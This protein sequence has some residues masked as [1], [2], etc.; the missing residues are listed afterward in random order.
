MPVTKVNKSE[1]L[2][3]CWE[4]FHRNGY[5]NASLQS[6]ADASGLGKAGV[7]H[8][9]GSKEGLMHAVLEFSIEA[10]KAYVLAPAHE[11]L[12]PDQQLEKL[13]RRQNRLSKRE[14]QGCFYANVGLET[15]R[16]GVFNEKVQ[17]AYDLWIET[18]AGI[19]QPTY[20]PD[21]ARAAAYRMLL[22]YEGAVLMYKLSG[23]ESHL[24]GVVNR[25]VDAFRN[26]ASLNK[27]NK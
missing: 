20:T 4:V 23:D 6:L 3:R 17:Y 13:L 25:A 21:A 8:H 26:E 18:V 1:I 5:N 2:A 15:G 12:P 11:D 16:S 19:L 22:E 7:L 14:R 27:K 9:F 10:F 24:E